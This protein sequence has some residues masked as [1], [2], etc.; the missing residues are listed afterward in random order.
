MF[1]DNI[2]L[3]TN[4][5]HWKLQDWCFNGEL[6]TNKPMNY[7]PYFWTIVFTVMFL[8]AILIVKLIV[9]ILLRIGKGYLKFDEWYTTNCVEPRV[10]RRMQRKVKKRNN[11][12]KT[13]G[14]HFI[15]LAYYKGYYY[16]H[17]NESEKRVYE[18]LDLD[19]AKFKLSDEDHI[20]YQ[21]WKDRTP[22]WEA[23]LD[24]RLK[25]TVLATALFKAETKAALAKKEKRAAKWAPMKSSMIGI[26]NKIIK[27]TS[28][29]APALVIGVLLY[30]CYLLGTM[31]VANWC[32]T[33]VWQKTAIALATLLGVGVVVVIV[34]LIF[35]GLQRFF[36]GGWLGKFLGTALSGFFYGI[37][38]YTLRPLGR[39][40]A[41][42]FTMF[43]SWKKE[44]CP[45]IE[46][47]EPVRLKKKG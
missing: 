6:W 16:G 37:Y 10:E 32:W 27:A 17:W 30:L 34:R 44:N 25:E 41:I 11:S 9:V 24:K 26:R 18:Q 40:I 45:G 38:K 15:K 4:A 31:A 28:I 14:M 3:K 19:M 35:K 5:W 46:W 33:C 13:T 2:T 8:P 39:G 36:E 22:N 21:S 1:F 43:F 47:E 42:T 20:N 7:C 23:I 29:G 12:F